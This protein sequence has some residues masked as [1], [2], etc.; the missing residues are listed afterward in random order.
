MWRLAGSALVMAGIASALAG[1]G[2]ADSHAR[3]PDFLLAK[4]PEPR[5]SDP[6]PDVR[7][8]VR[9]N[10]AQVFTAASHPRHVRVS[11]PRRELNGMG[12]TACIKAELTSVTGR[13]LGTQ[14]Y[15]AT[16]NGGV[17]RDRR[18]VEA[19]DNCASETYEGI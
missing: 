17:I 2:G 11:P 18:R 9:D 10:L 5:P 7:Q 8:L 16:I 6:E 1:C 12:W 3:L 19:D 14:T 15:L 4:A 13:S